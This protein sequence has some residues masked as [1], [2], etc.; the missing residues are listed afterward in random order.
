LLSYEQRMAL[1][2]ALAAAA[3]PVDSVEGQ[4]ALSLLITSYNDANSTPRKTRFRPSDTGAFDGPR[5]VF[6]PAGFTEVVRAGSRQE[7]FRLTVPG[8]GAFSLEAFI[9]QAKDVDF[10]RLNAAVAGLRNEVQL[11]KAYVAMA[12]LRLKMAK[13]NTEPARQ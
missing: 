1:L 10:M 12:K 11:A 13:I 3:I 7:S 8:V 4:A 9:A 2:S 6:G 5:I